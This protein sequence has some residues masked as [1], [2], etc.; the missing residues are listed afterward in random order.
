[1]PFS[2][3]PHRHVLRLARAGAVRFRVAQKEG[4]CGERTSWGLR[5]GDEI[6]PGR[7]ATRLL[8][9]GKRYEAYLAWDDAM[10]TLVVVKLVRPGLVDTEH[11]LPRA[12]GRGRGA[13]DAEPPHDRPHVRRRARRRPPAPRARVPRRAAALD[14]RAEV[15]GHRRAAAAARA[16]ALLG[17]ALHARQAPAPPRRQAAQRRHVG[18]APPHR[19]E[20]RDDLRRRDVV[21]AAGRHERVH[22]ARAVRPRPL[23]GDRPAGRH[24]GPRRHPV[25]GAHPLAPVSPARLHR[26]RAARGCA[27]RSS[28]RTRSSRPKSVPAPLGR[29]HALVPGTPAGRSPDAPR[30][31]RRARA[32]GRLAPG[33]APR[34]SSGRGGRAAERSLA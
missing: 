22:G 9:G 19:P 34:A 6:V 12:R 28:S 15:P 29:A 21:H 32:D 18:P 31:R 1:M 23:L 14:A 33:A 25:R 3:P 30:A 17:A 5:E 2:P 11:V 20:H 16:R 4:G 26:G 24:L 7:V 13:R 10:H 27:T 8:G